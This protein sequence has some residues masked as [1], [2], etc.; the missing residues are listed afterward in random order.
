MPSKDLRRG[1]LSQAGQIYHVTTTTDGRQPLFLDFDCARLAIAELRRLQE[2]NLVHSLAWVLMP[3]HLHWLLQLRGPIALSSVIKA[4][5]GRSA[6]QL[7]MRSDAGGMVWQPG[8]HDHALRREE[9]IL[10]VARYIV[11]N[12]IRAGLV[13]RIGDY[14]FWDSHWL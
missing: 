14:P 7:G 3:D 12:P 1:R 13:E 9:D 11:A 4:F 8:F 2:Q 5:K 10:K 6:R